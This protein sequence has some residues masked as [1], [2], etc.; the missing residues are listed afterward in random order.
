MSFNTKFES[1]KRYK[2]SHEGRQLLGPFSKLVALIL[3]CNCVKSVIITNIVKQIKFKR[4]WGE[5][6]IEKP[7]SDT[8]MD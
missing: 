7:F 1:Q 3:G 2:N 8:I 5:L 6:E 4:V